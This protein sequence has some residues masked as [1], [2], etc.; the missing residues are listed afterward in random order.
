MFLKKKLTS[1]GLLIAILCIT[2]ITIYLNKQSNEIEQPIEQ[3]TVAVDSDEKKEDFIEAVEETEEAMA[4]EDPVREFLSKNVRKAVGRFSQHDLSIV[5]IGDSL[6][7]GIGDDEANGG[8]VGILEE[9]I[10]EEENL[11]SIE[12]FGRRGNRSDQLSQRLEEDD[13][14]IQAI[15]HADIILMTIGANDIMKVFKDNFTDL[16]IETFTSEQIR[17]E[18]RLNHIFAMLN[19]MN[20]DATIYL[21]GFYNP[22]QAYFPDIEELEYIITSWNQIGLDITSQ[23][24]NAHY[25]PIKDLFE[26]Q[27]TPLLAEDNFHPNHIGYELI[28]NRILNYVTNEG[29]INER[30]ETNE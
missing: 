10:N 13:D 24:D 2:I 27:D 7:E 5:S 30:T 3:E 23:Y 25:I 16:Q 17:Y 4:Q 26:D 6:T 29:E 19:E 12:N 14:V 28:A 1:I 21:I 18:Q 15:G 20:P 11:V 9:A 8:Y 22:F